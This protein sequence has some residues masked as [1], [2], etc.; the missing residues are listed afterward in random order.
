MSVNPQALQ[1][2]LM[3]MDSQLNKSRA[4]LS[5]CNLQLERTVTNLNIIQKTQKDLSGL[6]KNNEGVWEGVGKTFVQVPVSDY[7]Q[8]IEADEKE[9]TDSK[10][11][12][13][14][15]KA[16]LETTLEKTIDNMTQLVGKK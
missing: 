2:L 6:C 16:Y 7:L 12:L 4:E 1:K 3:E 5:M 15:K 10:S 8:T 13:E 11:S 14:K 9:F